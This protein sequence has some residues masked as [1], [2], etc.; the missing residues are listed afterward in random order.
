M[1]QRDPSLRH[2]ANQYLSEQKDRSFPGYFYNF[3][4][5]Y[6]Q[7]FSTDPAMMPDQKVA[8]SARDMNEERICIASLR[9]GLSQGKRQPGL[10][11]RDD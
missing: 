8:R 11:P 2:T 6:M 9:F 7:I 1:I 4:Q 10:P 3:L 5:S